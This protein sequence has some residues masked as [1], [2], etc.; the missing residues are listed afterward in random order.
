M[1]I[2]RATKCG[3]AFVKC[4]IPNFLGTPLAIRLARIMPAAVCARSFRL[5]VSSQGTVRAHF[6]QCRIAYQ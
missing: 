3:T 5:R 1:V 6:G 2:D 4:I